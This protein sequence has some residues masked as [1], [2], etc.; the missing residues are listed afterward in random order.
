[1]WPNR[2]EEFAAV[3]T[4]TGKANIQIVVER[5]RH[6]L[7]SEAFT[8]GGRTLGVTASFGISGFE[9]GEPPKFDQLIREADL[10]LYAAKGG[11]RNRIE[12]AGA[13]SP[14]DTRS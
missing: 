9:S 5:I 3:V 8:F 14:G 12:F 10:A 13:P 11:G 6:Q 4:H 1:M 2:G 7:E